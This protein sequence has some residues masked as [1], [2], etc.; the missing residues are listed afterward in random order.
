MVVPLEDTPYFLSE[1]VARTLP[2]LLFN[3]KNLFPLTKVRIA[4]FVKVVVPT[5]RFVF[6]IPSLLLPYRLSS[7]SNSGG[8]E[9]G[10]SEPSDAPLQ[11]MRHANKP[12]VH[13]N[14][15]LTSSSVRWQG[16]RCAYS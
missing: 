15:S 16:K 2:R 6:S 9:T 11:I 3:S 14:V 4:G 13:S 7:F 12:K 1:T 8:G 5:E 10:L